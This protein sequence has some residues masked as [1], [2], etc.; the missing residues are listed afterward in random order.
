MSTDNNS[1]QEEPQSHQQQ[2]AETVIEEDALPPPQH[3]SAEEEEN[4][5]V[6][7]DTN[8]VQDEVQ[9]DEEEIPIAIEVVSDE[10]EIDVDGVQYPK[11]EVISREP[12][13]F[14]DNVTITLGQPHNLVADGFVNFCMGNIHSGNDTFLQTHR[15]GGDELKNACHKIRGVQPGYARITEAYGLKNFKYIIHG[16]LPMVETK[17]LGVTPQLTYLS[18]ISVLDCALENNVKT[19][20][21]PPLFAIE[22]NISCYLTL[23]AVK[24]WKQDNPQGIDN[25]TIVCEL[26]SDFVAFHHQIPAIDTIDDFSA[27]SLDDFFPSLQYTTQDYPAQQG[28]VES[29]YNYAGNYYPTDEA[30]EYS[31]NEATRKV[32][33][34]MNVTQTLPRTENMLEQRSLIRNIQLHAEEPDTKEIHDLYQKMF[35][36]TDG[37]IR[38]QLSR[39]L[40]P[41]MLPIE[42]PDGRI[43]QYRLTTQSRNGD[44][45]YFRCSHCEFLSKKTETQ[46]RPKMTVRDG[47][48][49]G[50][51]YPM[52]HPECHPVTKR[53]IIVQQIDRQA[54]CKIMDQNMM[55]RQMYERENGI[56]EG[57]INEADLKLPQEAAETAAAVAGASK[58]KFPTWEQVRKQY[59]RLR[60]K[61]E[62]LAAAGQRRETHMP[63]VDAVPI[64]VQPDEKTITTDVIQ[65]AERQFDAEAFGMNEED[66]QNAEKVKHEMMYHPQQVYTTYASTSQITYD[67]E[68][69]EVIEEG[70]EYYEDPYP[71]RHG[72]IVKEEIAQ[73]RHQAKR[74]MLGMP[75]YS[76]LVMSNADTR[77]NHRM[78]ELEQMAPELVL[79][80]YPIEMESPPQHQ[81]KK[82]VS[83]IRKVKPAVAIVPRR[84]RNAPTDEQPSTSEPPPKK[85]PERRTS[86]NSSAAPP[87]PA[88]MEPSSSM[89]QEPVRRSGRQSLGRPPTR[90]TD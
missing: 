46:Y 13:V 16:I 24:K 30:Y 22:P 81:P 10:D 52:H 86:T 14:E 34:S 54:R 15:L 65:R 38:L 79:E 57:E 33:M 11:E 6:V 26:E 90:F 67:E 25:I 17:F 47:S 29:E 88:K 51:Y 74:Q 72:V 76:S 70:A 60:A 44:A 7:N 31:E 89:S 83:I 53:Q 43:R 69:N 55:M 61:G 37:G 64:M 5:A 77:Y 84:K 21:M 42:E 18:I 41:T 78:T 58:V 27:E 50:S 87:T 63:F 62:K 4:V 12:I 80:E 20:I 40:S 73:E 75:R 56:S 19:L 28:Y 9:G 45:Y 59:Y 68:G 39:N 32:D 36:L 48:I 71:Q 23:L 1:E 82:R 2:P 8:A 49:V 66:I 3:Q 85:Q 35:Y